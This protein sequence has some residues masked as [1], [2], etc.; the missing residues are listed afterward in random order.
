[1]YSYHPQLARVRELL[2]AGAIGRLRLIRASFSFLADPVEDAHLLTGPDGG[3]LLDVGCYCVHLS[4]T[5]CGEPENVYAAQ[6]SNE[7]AVDIRLAATLHFPNGILSQFDSG[8][9]MPQRELLELVGEAGTIS[10]T[11]PWAQLR[12]AEIAITH[13]DKTDRLEL[14][15]IDAYRLEIEAFSAA[16]R[17]QTGGILGRADAVSNARVLESLT[18][19]A[20]HREPVSLLPQG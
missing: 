10:L 18:R 20:L 9:D 11:D 8:L 2:D 6:V 1:M 16:V 17:G 12:P 5:L 19:S 14:G 15:T 4:R 7:H 3:S 13:G